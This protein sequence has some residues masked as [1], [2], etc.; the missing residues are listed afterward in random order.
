MIDKS[1]S[2]NQIIVKVNKTCKKCGIE[3]N[4]KNE[5]RYNHNR[6]YVHPNCKDCKREINRKHTQKRA[7]TLKAHPLW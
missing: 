1:K 2:P 5:V 3:L 7:D 6:G 4:K